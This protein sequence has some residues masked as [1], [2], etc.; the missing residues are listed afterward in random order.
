MLSLRFD[1]RD[2]FKAPRIAL[3]MQRLWIQFLGMGIGY[4]GYLILSYLGFLLNGMDLSVVWSQFGLLPC[5]FAC[6]HS[7]I[8]YSWIVM[9]L[10]H[11][12]LLIAYLVTATAVSRAAYMVS[13]GNHF[14]TWR[15]A[16]SFSVRKIWSVLLTPVSLAVLIGLMFLGGA[17]VGLLGKIPYIGELGISLFTIIWFVAALFILFFA[18]ILAVSILLTPAIL[19]TT[20]EDAFEAIFQTFSLVWSQPVRLIV[21]EAIVGAL[22]IIAVGVFA[23]FVKQAV[24]LM[25]WMFA[26]VMGS[27][28]IHLAQNGQTTLQAW[29]ILGRDLLEPIF[30]EFTSMIYFSRMIPGLDPETLPITVVIASYIYALSL[31]ALAG[32]VL[33]Y[34]LSTFAVGNTLLYTV[35]RNIKDDD[36]ILERKDAEEEDETDE[37]PSDEE[38]K[39]TEG[40]GSS[41]DET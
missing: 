40:E 11:L 26:S 18:I 10:S 36:N 12:F 37:L 19:A 39:E 34:G 6:G 33:A 2:L 22:S 31:L 30:G 29:L 28:F 3:S 7:M 21:Y 20:D 35:I 17:V 41:Q 15:E 4:V 27:D 13:K 5:S 16:F 14:Y 1:F 23:L 9:I 25:N 24:V 38:I 32:W 8:W